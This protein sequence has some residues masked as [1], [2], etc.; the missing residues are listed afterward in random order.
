MLFFSDTFQYTGK[1]L[2]PS[3]ESDRILV[4]QAKKD[5][6]A[7]GKL[8]ER[9]EVP[10]K[11]YLRRLTGWG[12]EEVMDILQESFIKAYRY[13]NNYDAGLKF[14]TWLYRITHNQAIDMLR[15]AETRPFLKSVDIDEMAEFLPSSQD[16][17]AQFLR[18]D[19]MNRVRLAILSLPLP[20]RDVLVLRYLEECSYEEIMD[21]LKKPK[22]S[23]ATLISRGRTLL[24]KRL[25]SLD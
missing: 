7:F 5:P 17:E 16:T 3:D 24:M 22:G 18:Q 9:Y 1:S 11:R 15:R 13:L 2:A 23:I 20:Y 19:D 12:D 21:I 4:Q 14:S 8:M 10:L 25:V 6:E